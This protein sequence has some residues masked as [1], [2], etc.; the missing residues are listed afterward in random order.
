VGIRRSSQVLV[1]RDEELD[2]LG[3]A[4][5]GRAERPL[6]LLDLPETR[7]YLLTLFDFAARRFPDNELFQRALGRVAQEQARYEAAA[8]E[9]SLAP[10]A[11]GIAIIDPSVPAATRQ[12]IDRILS[13]GPVLESREFRVIPPPT[14]PGPRPGEPT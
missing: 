1:G 3:M 9:S 6:I 11:Y 7:T 8:P 10:G 4:F 2:A 5:A 14:V 12:D 13:S